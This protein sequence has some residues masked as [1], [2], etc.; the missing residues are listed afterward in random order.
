MDFSFNTS[1][2]VLIP[3]IYATIASPPD[4]QATLFFLMS[5]QVYMLLFD[6][7][8][9]NVIEDLTLVKQGK[10]FAGWYEIYY[11]YAKLRH[12]LYIEANFKK[13]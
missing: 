6:S 2:F 9:I 12:L 11:D 3:L 8:A 4:K 7:T 5:A 1:Q 10:S 13:S